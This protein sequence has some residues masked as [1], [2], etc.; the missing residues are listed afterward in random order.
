MKKCGTILLLLTAVL[1][2]CNPKGADNSKNATPGN[3]NVTD[4]SGDIAAETSPAEIIGFCDTIPI[5]S[6]APNSPSMKINVALELALQM[7]SSSDDNPSEMSI[8]D[9][10]TT[11]IRSN[12]SMISFLALGFNCRSIKYSLPAKSGS[13]PFP[14]LLE[15]K[16]TEEGEINEWF[17]WKVKKDF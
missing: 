12:D 11:L 8:M 17:F 16:K 2:S 15:N 13:E 4:A 14:E 10:G 1:C 9:V 6:Y 5:D 3:D 7:W